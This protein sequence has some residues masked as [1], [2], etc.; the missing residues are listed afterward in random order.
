MYRGIGLENRKTKT[1][2]TD[3]IIDTVL[4]GALVLLLTRWKLARAVLFDSLW[5]PLTRSVIKGSRAY[6]DS[7]APGEQSRNAPHGAMVNH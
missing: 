3:L 2:T 6:H 7:Q 4:A 1:V 5:H